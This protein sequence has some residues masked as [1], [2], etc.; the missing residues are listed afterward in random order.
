MNL[1]FLLFYLE[2]FSLFPLNC[3]FN[4][5][6]HH[7]RQECVQWK[8]KALFYMSLFISQEIL[9]QVPSG[10]LLLILLGHISVIKP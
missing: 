2:H 1:G 10:D 5:F 4:S 6:R 7:Q 8:K 3:E 9:S